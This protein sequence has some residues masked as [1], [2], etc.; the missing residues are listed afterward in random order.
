MIKERD[1]RRGSQHVLGLLQER[2]ERWLFFGDERRRPDGEHSSPAHIPDRRLIGARRPGTIRCGPSPARG[3]GNPDDPPPNLHLFV[4]QVAKPSLVDPGN[5]RLGRFSFSEPGKGDPARLA[6]TRCPSTATSSAEVSVRSRYPFN[7]C[8]VRCSAMGRYLSSTL[9]GRDAPT[10]LVSPS[11]FFRNSRFD[12]RLG[13]VRSRYHP[14]LITF[15]ALSSSITLAMRPSSS[16]KRFQ[17]TANRCLP[18]MTAS[19]AGPPFRSRPV[20]ATR[21]AIA[22]RNPSATPLPPPSRCRSP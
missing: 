9:G 19:R 15:W 8:S 14:Q 20:R 3:P 22:G 18:S 6:E 2:P 7:S 13:Q 5:D 21:R 1:Q 10:I 4:T 17:I 12:Q 11:S 16:G